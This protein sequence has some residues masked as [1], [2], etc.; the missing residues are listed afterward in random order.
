LTTALVPVATPAIF[1][2][3]SII[4]PKRERLSFLDPTANAVS[5]SGATV[6][7]FLFGFLVV[8]PFGDIYNTIN[9]LC[10]AN[11]VI[12]VGPATLIA[13]VIPFL[14][15][16]GKRQIKGLAANIVLFGL[17]SQSPSYF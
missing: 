7:V 9:I 17:P 14:V 16:V 10:F 15:T 3:G 12:I 2:I 13:L 4:D 11:D 6:G 1:I 5:L 8:L